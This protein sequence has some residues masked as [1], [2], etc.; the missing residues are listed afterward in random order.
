MKTCEYCDR[1]KAKYKYHSARFL[2]NG[3]DV[4]EDC[5]FDMLELDDRIESST[6]TTYYL[7]GECIGDS[8]EGLEM[9]ISEIAKHFGIETLEN[10]EVEID[11]K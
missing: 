5:L 2:P 9:E 1:E 3:V 11:E 7:D 6:T 4:C 10:Q 8:D